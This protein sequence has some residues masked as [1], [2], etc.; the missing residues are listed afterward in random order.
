MYRAL[1]EALG[2]RRMTLRTLDVGGDKPLPYAPQPPEANP[3]LGMRGIRLA[4]AQSDLLDAQLRAF[5][6]VAHETP[7]QCDVPDGEHVERARCMPSNAWTRRST[8][9]GRGRPEALHVGIM[10]EVPAAAL[11]A[12]SFAPHIDFF[13]I[14]TNDL[15]QYALAAERGNAAVAALGDPLDPGVLRLVESVCRAADGR[16][17][18]AVCGELAAD[19]SA[20]PAPRR[21][22]CARAERGSVLGRGHQARGTKHRRRCRLRPGGSLPH[23]GRSDRGTR[24]P[25]QNLQRSEGA[26]S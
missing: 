26:C 20:T 23:G 18:V 12:E 4:F 24:Y 13:S 22:G 1:A 11:K 14:G 16:C 15:T 8:H 9:V 21:A 2:G 7:G 6:T 3:F 5:V 17:L 10:V 19:E 25:R